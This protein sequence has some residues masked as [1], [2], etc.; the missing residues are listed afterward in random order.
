M[1]LNLHGM[2]NIEAETAERTKVIAIADFQCGY[3]FVDA[4]Y[5]NYKRLK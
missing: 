2:K 3:W 5:E 4:D 1:I